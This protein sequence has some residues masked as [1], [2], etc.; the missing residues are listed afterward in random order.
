MDRPAVVTEFAVNASGALSASNVYRAIV[1]NKAQLTYN[2][3][4]AWLEGTAPAPPK[5]A[6]SAELQAQLKLQDQVAQALKK[7]R[8]E[9]GALNL[10]TSEVVPLLYDG[11]VVDVVKASKNR[12]TDLIEDFMVAANG[13][14]ARLLEKVSSLRRIVRTPAHWDGIVRLA[15]AQGEDLSATPRCV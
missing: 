3:V 6:A 5:V 9:H 13:V 4:G 14:V 15:A 8:Y 11:Q 7:L 12:A 2:A 1:R 10:D